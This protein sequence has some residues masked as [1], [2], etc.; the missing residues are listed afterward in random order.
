MFQITFV[1]RRSQVR[2]GVQLWKRGTKRGEQPNVYTGETS[3]NSITLRKVY[4]VRLFWAVSKVVSF[5]HS[6]VVK[7]TSSLQGTPY[8]WILIVVVIELKT[9]QKAVM[10][11]PHKYHDVELDLFTNVKTDVYARSKWRCESQKA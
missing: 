2:N 3:S 7:A 5:F 6:S 11:M 9:Y 1:A 8:N 10:V 4:R